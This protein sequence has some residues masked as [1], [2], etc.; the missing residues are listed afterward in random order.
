MVRVL[1][2]DMQAASVKIAPTG[3]PVQPLTNGL[4]RVIGAVYDITAGK[5]DLTVTAGPS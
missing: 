4:G 2:A 5:Y 3:Q 1:G